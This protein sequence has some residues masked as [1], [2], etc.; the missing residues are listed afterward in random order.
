[1]NND[2]SAH[3]RKLSAAVTELS[4][5]CRLAPELTHL[6]HRAWAELHEIADTLGFSNGECFE[7]LKHPSEKPA[8][9]AWMSLSVVA[10]GGVLLSLSLG[11]RSERLSMMLQFGKW[12]LLEAIPFGADQYLCWLPGRAPQVRSCAE[13]RELCRQAA[14]SYLRPWGSP[15]IS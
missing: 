13:V 15:E 9:D 7:D 5:K 10:A 14:E 8:G 2:D 6:M 3:D 11:R 1:M 12:I 4:Q